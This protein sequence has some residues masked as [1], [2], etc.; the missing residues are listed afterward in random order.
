[1]TDEQV[2]TWRLVREIVVNPEYSIS[3]EYGNV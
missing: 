2:C 1:M 3:R